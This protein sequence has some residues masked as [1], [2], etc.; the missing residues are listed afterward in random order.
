MPAITQKIGPP[1]A[2][3]T[4]TSTELESSPQ[5]SAGFLL[6]NE[7]AVRNNFDRVIAHSLKKLTRHEK[8]LVLS[9]ICARDLQIGASV[10]KNLKLTTP[11]IMTV[12]SSA[13]FQ[14]A[15]PN[16]V[17]NVQHFVRQ[18][19]SDYSK[20]TA[21]VAHEFINDQ[22][23]LNTPN[24][25]R[26]SN[27]LNE[28]LATMHGLLKGSNFHADLSKRQAVGTGIPLAY[29]RAAHL[30]TGLDRLLNGE[31]YGPRVAQLIEQK[32]NGTV[33]TE[34]KGILTHKELDDLLKQHSLE[35]DSA[36]INDIERTARRKKDSMIF[37]LQREAALKEMAAD[38]AEIAAHSGIGDAVLGYRSGLLG[39]YSKQNAEKI[40]MEL[41]H[42]ASATLNLWKM[43][44]ASINIALPNIATSNSIYNQEEI[45]R[46]CHRLYNDDLI[47]RV[48]ENPAIFYHL[49]RSHL[50]HLPQ[51][52]RHDAL[53]LIEQSQHVYLY[54]GIQV[55]AGT[56][57]G[58]K[59]F[60]CW[61]QSNAPATSYLSLE[62][63][64]DQSMEFSD[65]QPRFNPPNEGHVVT[66]NHQV[67]VKEDPS[68]INPNNP[69]YQIFQFKHNAGG[70][71]V[72]VA[73][74]LLAQNSVNNA[75]E[76]RLRLLSNSKNEH[77]IIFTEKTGISSNL[78]E[79]FRLHML[80]NAGSIDRDIKD[81]SLASQILTNS[82]EL[83]SVQQKTDGISV[84]SERIQIIDPQHPEDDYVFE[85]D[86]SVW[87]LA[88]SDQDTYLV[89]SDSIERK[90][91]LKRLN[92]SGSPTPALETVGKVPDGMTE[93]QD[94]FTYQGKDYFIL[95]SHD[96]TR[97]RLY[98]QQLQ[99]ISPIFSSL[100]LVETSPSPMFVAQTST[101]LEIFTTQPLYD[102][103][104]NQH[105]APIHST[106]ILP[107]LAEALIT[108]SVD[109]IKNAAQQIE[110]H[111]KWRIQD[112]ISS[113]QLMILEA[114]RRE[115]RKQ[116]QDLDFHR[117]VANGF[118]YQDCQKVIYQSFQPLLGDS[119]HNSLLA[120]LGEMG[121]FLRDMFQRD[122]VANDYLNSFSPNEATAQGGNPRDVGLNQST[123]AT[124]NRSVRGFIFRSVH[125]TYNPDSY[126]WLRSCPT[127]TLNA[128]ESITTVSAK[129]KIDSNSPVIT[130]S[131]PGNS[132]LS[133]PVTGSK[134]LGSTR[135]NLDR[136]D[137]Q[138]WVPNIN[139][140]AGT[141][142]INYQFSIYAASKIDRTISSFQYRQ[143]ITNQTDFRAA[144]IPL[145]KLPPE[146]QTFCDSI[147]D[148]P[149]YE[150]IKKTQAFV[151]SIGFYDM[152]NGLVSEAKVRKP[153]A[154]KIAIMQARM[155]MI[156]SDSKLPNAQK[157]LAMVCADAAE[158]GVALLREVGIAAGYAEGYVANGKVLKGSTAHAIGV[159]PWPTAEPGQFTL[160]EVDF[161]P[162]SSSIEGLKRLAQ[163]FGL[164]AKE[165]TESTSEETIELNQNQDGLGLPIF[166]DLKFS[167]E[168]VLEQYLTKSDEAVIID[169]VTQTLFGPRQSKQLIIQES[170]IQKCLLDPE[171]YLKSQP[172]NLASAS[173]A[174]EYLKN[175]T[176]DLELKNTLQQYLIEHPALSENAKDYL[177]V[178]WQTEI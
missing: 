61:S 49:D 53:T 121:G 65:F 74:G 27:R 102:S 58:Q 55:D 123:I 112:H 172:N 153:I 151:K 16:F 40:L 149:P 41:P 85:L 30:I 144:A 108:G 98:D 23:L 103:T 80:S 22:D 136:L 126:T 170:L 125:L 2:A 150:K 133:A 167:P 160:M 117:N 10:I 177:R 71:F 76:R 146:M 3:P 134:G 29:A 43:H 18:H 48:P 82:G 5:N 91:Y 129:S 68:S 73:T 89:L 45:R 77:A 128:G 37:A 173:S 142:E 165:K 166:R 93:L 156:N 44:S 164:T 118:S 87:G 157:K 169:A 78:K 140:L 120:N 96:P 139:N 9:E 11:E 38:L 42:Q 104:T 69:A 131:I 25:S 109:K 6:G 84:L 119:H 59:V 4:K 66:W 1:T 33:T 95:A 99:P 39:L 21:A 28:A 62:E 174:L 50:R 47:I 54:S 72:A 124:F 107:V 63:S 175:S 101:G 110:S 159:V 135:L 138:D 100:V 8:L 137:S 57:I 83:L 161:T 88:N 14:N 115:M 113:K 171:S 67:L 162:E 155:A 132:E 79:T 36:L 12:M 92:I 176:L 81:R 86:G 178:S 111:D 152:D 51:E 148:L 52:E 26:S 154:E 105:A 60:P 147:R 64:L 75:Q 116:H 56:S 163:L 46:P 90:R 35:T 24:P 143:Q 168:E 19:M 106:H 130:L 94:A 31:Y 145:G 7:Q 114:A 15:F 32:T 141:S 158:V 20:A 97:M 70:E 122:S 17:K 13:T 127:P 34:K